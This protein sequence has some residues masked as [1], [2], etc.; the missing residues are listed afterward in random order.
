[1]CGEAGALNILIVLIALAV[2]LAV[3]KVGIVAGWPFLMGAGVGW[4]VGWFNR[5]MVIQDQ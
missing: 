2:A 3:F 1:L 5:D 4:L